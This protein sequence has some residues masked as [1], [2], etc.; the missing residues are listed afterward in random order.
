VATRL[1]FGF[2]TE[3]LNSGQRKNIVKKKLMELSKVIRLAQMKWRISLQV[4]CEHWNGGKP[5]ESYHANA[6]ASKLVDVS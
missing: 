1:T 5:F 4:K 3:V 6:V 2:R